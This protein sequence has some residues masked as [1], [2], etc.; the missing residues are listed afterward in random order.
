MPR[1]HSGYHKH[2]P[3]HDATMK[4]WTQCVTPDQ[5]A[6]NPLRQSAHGS[7]VKRDRCHCGAYRDTEINQQC[8]N[9]GPWVT[10]A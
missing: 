9:Y 6:A 8:R 10:N 3:I 4:G 5:C 1:R 2:Q 7:I